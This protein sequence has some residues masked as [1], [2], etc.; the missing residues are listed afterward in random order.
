MK[1][2]FALMMALVLMMSICPA[3][4]AGLDMS[5]VDKHAD[6]Y[7]V[8]IPEDEPTKA[9][10]DT[11]NGFGVDELAFEH[12]Y[13]HPNRYSYIS[14][15]IIVFDYGTD[16]AEAYLRTWIC[17]EGTEPIYATSCTFVV[18]GVKYTLS[19]LSDPDDMGV[20]DGGVYQDMCILYD[21]KNMDVLSALYSFVQTR[22][23]QEDYDSIEIPVILHGTE[24]LEIVMGGMSLLDLCYM[25]DA[26]DFMGALA[27]MAPLSNASPLTIE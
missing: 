21:T 18:D 4:A 20:D 22:I 17:Y 6:V 19:D 2:F 8:Y 23:E 26:F 3:F 12:K 24:D 1:K 25:L 14:T 9:F 27:M 5:Y 16:D 10:I 13:E 15:D 11:S 7:S